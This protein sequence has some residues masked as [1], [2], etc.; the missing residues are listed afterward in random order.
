MSPSNRQLEERQMRK[1]R[2]LNGALSVF[3][4]KGLD[5]ATMDEIASNSGF[6]KATLYYYFKSKE[7]VFSAILEDG[8]IKNYFTEDIDFDVE[9]LESN[10]TSKSADFDLDI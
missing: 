8:W 9:K 7:D 5:G 1:D 10:K 6:G 4:A 2:I 3:K